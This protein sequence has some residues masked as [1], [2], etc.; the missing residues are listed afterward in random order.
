MPNRTIIT[1]NT[2]EVYPAYTMW[3]Q[4]DQLL[5][6]TLLASLSTEVLSLS[7]GCTISHVDLERR[8]WL[9][10]PNC[11][12]ID[13]MNM[14]ASWIDSKAFAIQNNDMYCVWTTDMLLTTSTMTIKPHNHQR[15]YYQSRVALTAIARG[16]LS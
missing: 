13:T 16:G 5:I 10:D 3:L 7:I 2:I 15:K 1:N 9:G 12:I 8:K 4:Q 11:H 6:S 14:V